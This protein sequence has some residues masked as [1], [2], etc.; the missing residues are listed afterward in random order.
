MINII[1][2][3]FVVVAKLF[4]KRQ[5]CFVRANNCNACVLARRRNYWR[6]V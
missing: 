2:W 1:G 3:M 6:T 5:I 4:R